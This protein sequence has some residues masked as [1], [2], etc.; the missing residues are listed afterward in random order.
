MIA[1]LVRTKEDEEVS[2]VIDNHAK[3]RGYVYEQNQI[4]Q[5]LLILYS[6]LLFNILQTLLINCFQ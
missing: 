3:Y 6:D 4:L 2:D 1:V 5:S